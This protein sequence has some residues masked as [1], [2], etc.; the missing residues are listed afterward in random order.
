[1]MKPFLNFILGTTFAVFGLS[2]AAQA[3][4]DL[5]DFNGIAGNNPVW[6]NCSGN[7]YTLNLQSPNNI[8]PWTINWGD[9]TPLQ[10]GA[11]LVPPQSIPHVYLSAVDIYTVTF[12]ETATGCTITGTLYMEEPTSASIQIPVGGVTQACA[13]QTMEFINSSTNTSTTTA[14]TW[15]FGDGSPPQVFDFTNLGQTIAHTYQQGTV[16]CETVVTLIAEN[17]CNTVQGGPSQ[18]TFN[19]I[20]IWDIDDAGIGASDLV[21]CWPDNEFTFT[22]NTERNC[23]FQGNIFQR[24][25][26]WNFGDYWGLGYDSIVD[27]RAWPPTFPQ[28]MVY[29]AIG[30]YQVTLLDSNI[31]GIDVASITVEIVAPPTA[32]ASAAPTTICEGQTVTF[33]NTSSA[34]VTDNIWDFGDGSPPVFSGA[35]SLQHVYPNAGNYTATLLVAVGGP[36]SGCNDQISI[37]ITVL[38]G[39]DAE[40]GFDIDEACDD[41]TVN[42]SDLSTGALIGWEW[43]FGNGNTGL[44]QNP[45]PENYPNVGAYNVILTVEA[46]NGCKNSDT[47]IVRV[48]ESPVAQFMAQ[49]VCIGAVGSFTDLSSSMA[50]DPITNWT[51]NFGNGNTS[52]AQNPTNIYNTIGN[53]LVT[54]DVN[55]A[56]CSD[57][58]Q[59]NVN[60]EPAPTSG[61]DASTT[62]GCG[63]LTVDFSNTSTGAVNYTW[64]FGD[65][66]GTAEENPQH[67]FLN[68]G[69]VDSVYTVRL[70]AATA[71]GCTDTSSIDITVNPGAQA[72]FQSFYLPSCAPM[73][74]TFLNN[75]QS[76]SGYIWDFGDGSPLSNEVNPTHEFSNSTQFLVNYTIQ[77]V[78]LTPNGCNDTTTASISVFPEPNFQFNLPVAEGCAPYVL[79]LPLVSGAVTYAWN[80]GDGTIS[81]SPAPSHTYFNNTLDTVSYTT[82]LVATSAFG[83]KDTSETEVTVYPNPIAQFS[84]NLLAGCSPLTVG[85]EN[86]SILADSVNWNYGDGTVSDTLSTDHDHTFVNSTNQTVTYTITLTAFTANGCSRNFTRTIQ[87][88]PEVTAAFEHPL[89]GCSPI[90]FIAQN[91]SQNG[92]IYQWDF[93]NGTGSLAPNPLVGYANNT[94]VPDTFDITLVATSAFGCEDTS[95]SSVVVFPK[96]QAA[97]FADVTTGCSPLTVTFQNT[98]STADSY[99]WNYGDGSGSDTS[100]TAHSHVFQSFMNIPQNYGVSLVAVSNF[101]CSDTTQGQ[102]TVYPEVQAN[103]QPEAE[104]CSPLPVNFVNQ[105]FGAV[106]YVWQFGDGNQSFQ[107]NASHTFVNNQDTVFDFNVMM[108]AQSAFGC[109]DTAFQNVKVFPLPSVALAVENIEGCFPANFTFGNYSTG[110][111]DFIWDYGDGNSSENGQASHVHTFVNNTLNV[112]TYTVTLTGITEYGCTRDAGINVDVIP[113]ITANVSFPPGGCSPYT[114][115]FENNSL[116]AFS[117][118]WDFGDGNSTESNSPTY[119]FTNPGVED[120]VYTVIFIARSL[121]GCADT[122]EFEVPVFGQPEAQFLAAPTVQQF[123]EATI[124][125]VNLSAANST[126]YYTWRWGDGI[127]AE[128]NDPNS[129][130]TYTYATWGQY[131]VELWVGNELCFDTAVQQVTILPPL[132][133]AAFS[134][135]GEGCLPLV[136]DF[137]NESTYGVSFEWNFGDGTTSNEEN[138]T[139]V[140]YTAGTFNVTL[141]VTGPGGQVDVAAAPGAV[142][143]HPRAEAFFTINPPVITVPDQVFFLN[144]STNAGIYTWDFGDGNISNAVSPHHFYETTGWHGVTLIANNIHNCPDTFAIDQAVKGNIDSQIAFPNAF[145][146]SSTG[147]TGGWWNIDDVFNNDV[148]FPQYKGVEDFEMQV[149]NRWGELLFESRDIRQGWDGYYRGLLCQQDVYVWRVRV[150]FLD[151]GELTDIGDVTLIR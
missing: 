42:F 131:D 134:G 8:G 138:P 143:V 6:Y 48:H 26:Y 145:T 114:A 34:N 124:D 108:V 96:P 13:P 109:T 78:A 95:R 120:E 32:N 85:F 126:A 31:C 22:N 150:T 11:E 60:V 119:T 147:P 33:T 116:G 4:C 45:A 100:A 87:V 139:Q 82:Q 73:P 43:S 10:S 21:L 121:W 29:P 47:H 49:D 55:T 28:T 2:H 132:P 129:P 142:V 7:N 140:Y 136:V 130:N 59:M 57:Q 101:G 9:G 19:P 75:S 38:P 148:F 106:S 54:L 115:T 80:F 97:Y 118:L 52:T 46:T 105:S 122:L 25:E 133:I 146:P 76:A 117:Y 88:Y 83:C 84:A 27:W 50:G 123:P 66:A 81:A 111:E 93:G 98:S 44:D 77:L 68:F 56:H 137:T 58:V 18:A 20:R 110:A 37:P 41:L 24:Y 16:D 90:S 65:G 35:A 1:M 86:Q 125:I 36:A 63:P 39:P 51:W 72:L 64:L 23:L 5:F 71:F 17:A 149:F 128:S 127:M 67:T 30:T 113:E 112:A 14:F 102:V 151:G 103:F 89:Q 104:G 94:A 15:V 74:A 107:P 92:S 69:T 135:E 79:Q 3:Q 99:L 61:F 62:G 53:Y 12:T 141:T 40:I 144:L 91:T 70:I